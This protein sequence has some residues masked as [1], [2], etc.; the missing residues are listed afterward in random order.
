M[1][2]RSDPVSGERD[3]LL[4][5]MRRRH[6]AAEEFTR[7]KA[8]LGEFAELDYLQLRFG[9]ELLRTAERLVQLLSDEVELNQRLSAFAVGMQEAGVI[10][11]EEL[12][13]LTGLA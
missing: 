2:H 8:R 3:A 13:V 10:T 12:N 9:P 11:I 5:A 1:P 7:I 4:A 6:E